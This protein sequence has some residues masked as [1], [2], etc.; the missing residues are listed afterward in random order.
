MAGYGRHRTQFLKN[1]WVGMSKELDMDISRLWN[2]NLDRDDRVISSHGKEV[3][4]PFLDESFIAHIRQLPLWHITN[5]NLPPGTGDKQILR[6]AAQILGIGQ[7]ASF[8]KRAIQ[9][10]SNIA[11]VTKT[12][13]GRAKGSDKLQISM[14]EED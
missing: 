2:R 3:R 12:S 4:S 9:F 1:G 7:A 10:G 14:A 13:S 6:K 5:M 11:K 8:V